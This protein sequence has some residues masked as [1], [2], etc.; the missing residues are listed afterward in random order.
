MEE[1]INVNVGVVITETDIEDIM[2]TALFGINYWADAVR[3][4]GERKGDDA[5]EH[6][7]NGGELRIHLSEGPITEGGPRWYTLNQKKMV[8]G[9]KQYLSDPETNTSDLLFYNGVRTELDPGDID[10]DAADLIV[11]YALF[12]EQVFA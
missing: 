6:I 1:L 7:A 12:G 11:Q 3:H 9:I 2:Q 5:C 8:Q 4:V 10:A